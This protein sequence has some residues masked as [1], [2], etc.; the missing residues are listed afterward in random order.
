MPTDA[1]DYIARDLDAAGVALQALVRQLRRQRRK[2]ASVT[3]ADILAI[4]VALTAVREVAATQ[5]V[6]LTDIDSAAAR[7]GRRS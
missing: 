4:G 3:E 7:K 5:G 2:G 1:P 6:R